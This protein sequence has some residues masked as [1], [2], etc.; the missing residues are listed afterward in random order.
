MRCPSCQQEVVLARICPYCGARV[1]GQEDGRAAGGGEEAARAAGRLE[2][3]VAAGGRQA[4]QAGEGGSEARGRFRGYLEGPRRGSRRGDSLGGL[5]PL[6]LIRY[7]MDRRVPAWKKW[8]LGVL[9]LYFLSPI[10]L[11][12]GALLPVLGWLDDLAVL[13]VAW[14]FL[15]EEL[16]RYAQ[17]ERVGWRP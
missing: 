12:P 15:T 13:S 3:Q 9:A 5:N 8:V 14:R 2:G 4:G 7:L 10:D 6:L 11:L 16:R 1:R 17:E